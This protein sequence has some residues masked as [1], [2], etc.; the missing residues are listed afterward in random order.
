MPRRQRLSSLV[1]MG[2]AGS[3]K[4]SLMAALENR[5]GWPA[6]EGDAVHPAS[7]VA[8]MAAGVPL[9]DLDRRPWL[10]AIAAWIGERESRRESSLVTCSALRREYRDILR[11]GHPWVWFVHLVAPPAVLEERLE[12]R[13]GHFMPA[14][15]L[16]SQLDTLEALEPD[17]PGT[18]LETDAPPDELAEELI[19]RLRLEPARVKAPRT[20]PRAT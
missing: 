5:L 3:G 1:L 15:L 11:R 9:S 12:H 7:N 16:G 8:K 10:E 20:P 4:S 18:T 2:V 6:L 13:A 17:E 14:T 19:E